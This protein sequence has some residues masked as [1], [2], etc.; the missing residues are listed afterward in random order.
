MPI[1]FELAALSL[2]A[3]AAG[4]GIGWLLWSDKSADSQAPHTSFETEK[5]TN[6]P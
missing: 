1:W 4:L 6:A 5:G 3:Y 2:A